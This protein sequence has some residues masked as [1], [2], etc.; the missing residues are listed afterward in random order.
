MIR[1]VTGCGLRVV[2][3]PS[4]DALR[5][6]A[7]VGTGL[8]DAASYAGLPAS[9][10]P[11]LHVRGVDELLALLARVVPRPVAGKTSCRSHPPPAND[12]P[13]VP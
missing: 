1:A 3:K 10:R 13:E 8:G 4:P 12:V 11:H 7:A 9:R 5:T 2:G 6:A